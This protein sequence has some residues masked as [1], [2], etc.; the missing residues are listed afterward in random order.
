MSLSFSVGCLFY[1]LIYF[2]TY[3]KIGRIFRPEIK[4]H[5]EA[6]PV[7]I[8]QQKDN[9]PKLLQVLYDYLAGNC[10]HESFKAKGD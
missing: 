1:L 4:L 7:F 10:F 6:Y 5:R 3:S 9:L 2:K 8:L